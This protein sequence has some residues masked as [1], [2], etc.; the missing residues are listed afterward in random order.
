MLFTI[1]VEDG[2]WTAASETFASPA[3][4]FH[5]FEDITFR[6]VAIDPS[7]SEHSVIV[8]FD[9]GKVNLCSISVDYSEQNSEV[10]WPAIQ[11]SNIDPLSLV[12][13]GECDVQEDGV[14]VQET[15]DWLCMNRVKSS[16]QLS[17]EH[18]AANYLEYRFHV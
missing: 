11:A 3:K 17:V 18:P 8:R 13:F 6:M 15:E 16:C 4:G 12:E 2:G 1:A 9:D 5:D 14:I 7:R 10:T